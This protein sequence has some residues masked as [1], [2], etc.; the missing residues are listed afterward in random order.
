MKRWLCM[1]LAAVSILSAAAGNLLK[2]SDFTDLNTKHQPV[3]WICRGKAENYRFTAGKAEVKGNKNY[4]I[5]PLN[6]AIGKDVVFSCLV[7]GK[8]RFSIYAE[9]YWTENGKRRSRSTQG[10]WL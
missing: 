1:W 8:G 4:L 9:W 3:G 2:N 6:Y 7:A 10:K 5:A